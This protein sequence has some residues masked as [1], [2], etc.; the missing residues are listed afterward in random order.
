MLSFSGA[1]V[2]PYFGNFN[3]TLETDLKRRH[4]GERVRYRMNGNSAISAHSVPKKEGRKNAVPKYHKR[5]NDRL[6]NALASVDDSRSVEEL[7]AAFKSVSWNGA[8]SARCVPGPMTRN[9]S[10]ILTTESFRSTACVT[11]TCTNSC[12]Q[13]NRNRRLTA[14]PFLSHQPKTPHAAGTWNHPESAAHLPLS[15]QRYRTPPSS[16]PF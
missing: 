3:G 1:D 2:M 15:G 9:F 6:R 13:P 10:P 12:T 14:D 16:W 4:E 5:A 7:T 8:K 11:E